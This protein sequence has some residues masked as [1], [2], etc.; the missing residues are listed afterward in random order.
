MLTAS[1]GLLTLGS[2]WLALV[3]RPGI[4][5]AELA[6][7]LIT[8]RVR[9]GLTFGLVDGAVLTVVAPG[10]AASPGYSGV[11]RGAPGYSGATFA[12]TR[13]A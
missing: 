2:A 7:P 13:T 9:L 4:K 1:L 3:L 5:A 6:G 10:G 11:L 12:T 8:L